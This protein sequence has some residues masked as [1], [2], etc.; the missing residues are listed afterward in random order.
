MKV[1]DSKSLVDWS[2]AWFDDHDS[3]DR[4]VYNDKTLLE[5][6]KSQIRLQKKKKAKLRKEYKE[7]IKNLGNNSIRSMTIGRGI[8][9]SQLKQKKKDELDKKIEDIS[10]E[11]ERL[12][13]LTV[14]QWYNE[15]TNE[16][17]FKMIND[18]SIRIKDNENT[19]NADTN[20]ETDFNGDEDLEIEDESV[21]DSVEV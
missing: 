11:M 5:N 9:A 18:K 16:L 13:R 2:H 12:E 1:D 3:I 20:P 15:L 14:D 17:K 4:I 10:I 7:N 8:I 6:K 21:D 19:T